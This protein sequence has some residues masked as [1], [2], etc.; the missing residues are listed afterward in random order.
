MIQFDALPIYNKDNK[1]ID[2]MLYDDVPEEERKQ[3]AQQV[4]DKVLSELS[5]IFWINFQQ[6]H[7]GYTFAFIGISAVL[8]FNILVGIYTARK[9]KKDQI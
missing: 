2:I 8:I 4:A 1:Y 3:L 5:Q 9:Y 6:E 7:L